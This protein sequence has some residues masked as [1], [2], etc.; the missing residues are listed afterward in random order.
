MVV[1]AGLFYHL[2][3]FACTA[4]L[5]ALTLAY[6]VVEESRGD[7]RIVR[8]IALTGRYRYQLR[9]DQSLTDEYSCHNPYFTRSATDCPEIGTAQFTA[10][11]SH[12]PSGQSPNMNSSTVISEV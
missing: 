3:V 7:D 8:A 11:T 12:E 2:N 1:A 5:E 10:A 9:L 6:R 4:K